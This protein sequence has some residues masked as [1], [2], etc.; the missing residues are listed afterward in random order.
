MLQK[1][2]RKQNFVPGW[3]TDNEWLQYD[4]EQNM[5]W[6]KICYELRD[7]FNLEKVHMDIGTT[8]LRLETVTSHKSSKVHKM[9]LLHKAGV[10]KPSETPLRRIQLLF[11][12]QNIE[13]FRVLFNLA[14][15]IAKRTGVFHNK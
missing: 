3:K 7:K 6:C 2:V 13:R 11:D 10:D 15:C 1:S 12:P 4:S 8:N 14:L 5:I 9:C